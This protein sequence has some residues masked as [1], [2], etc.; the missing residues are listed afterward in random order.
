LFRSTGKTAKN[1][2]ARE[3]DDFYP[4]P[5][6][7]TRA[8][9]AVEGQRLRQL[10][11]VWEPACGDGAMAREGV[12]GICYAEFEVTYANGNV[13]TFPN[14]SNIKVRVAPEVG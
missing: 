10:G 14:F 11:A 1:P 5:P 4:T 7:P 6:E 3:K 8:L 9:L 2:K 12:P 13:E